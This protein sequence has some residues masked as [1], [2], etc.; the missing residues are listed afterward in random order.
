[1]KSL[2]ASLLLALG[3]VGC[4]AHNTNRKYVENHPCTLMH[5]SG[6]DTYVAHGDVLYHT[7]TYL[8]SCDDV[9]A[10]VDVEGYPAPV[11]HTPKKAPHGFTLPSDINVEPCY[12][13]PD[14]HTVICTYGATK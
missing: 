1:M 7:P 13:D 5:M 4:S 14:S 2:T 6:G 3:M 11:S 12:S 9:D 10:W 8:F